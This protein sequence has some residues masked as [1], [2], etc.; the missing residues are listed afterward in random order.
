MGIILGI[1]F[2]MYLKY[3]TSKYSTRLIFI[4]GTFFTLHLWTQSKTHQIWSTET[5]VPIIK[6]SV[7]DTRIRSSDGSDPEPGSRSHRSIFD[8]H[9][10]LFSENTSK[11]TI[12]LKCH[13]I[14]IFQIHSCLLIYIF[15]I[16]MR[17]VSPIHR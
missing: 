11:P 14:T 9:L 3:L 2:N 10:K 8:L 15:R 12:T 6:T 1:Y 5:P 4:C 16:P 13:L 17:I 7:E